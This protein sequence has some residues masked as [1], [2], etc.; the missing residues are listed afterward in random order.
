M[1]RSISGLCVACDG[2]VRPAM[3]VPALDSLFLSLKV[4]VM[5][6]EVINLRRWHT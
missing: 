2:A 1:L 3:F 6:R 5:R 4:N